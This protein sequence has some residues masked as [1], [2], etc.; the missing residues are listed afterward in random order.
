LPSKTIELTKDGIVI[1]PV[2]PVLKTLAE[3]LNVSSLNSKG[4]DHNTRQLGQLVIDT[5][6]ALQIGSEAKT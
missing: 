3:K 6:N 1:S 5:A 4:G 2:K